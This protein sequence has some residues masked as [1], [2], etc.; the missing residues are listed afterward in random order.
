MDFWAPHLLTALDELAAAFGHVHVVLRVG[1]HGRTTKKPESKTQVRQNSDWYFGRVLALA[2]RNDERITW[3]MPDAP[4]GLVNVYQTTYLVEHGHAF[5]GGDQVAGP[6]RPVMKGYKDRLT[7]GYVFDQLLVGH[8][9][10][11]SFIPRVGMNGSLVGFNQ[12]ALDQHFPFEEPK[13]ALWIVTPEN[14]SMNHTAI[15]PMDRKAE[16]W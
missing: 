6:L 7:E 3:D 14:G 1:N 11:Y 10:S 4:L 13:Q 8:F 15:L 2:L 16:G 9:H 5:R 12:F